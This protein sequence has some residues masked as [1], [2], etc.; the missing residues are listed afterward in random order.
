MVLLALPRISFYASFCSALVGLTDVDDF[1]K[2][3]L[4]CFSGSRRLQ[5]PKIFLNLAVTAVPCMLDILLLT[6][7]A[8]VH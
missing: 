5:L 1:S 6:V 3:K 4:V 7:W 2:L 8:R